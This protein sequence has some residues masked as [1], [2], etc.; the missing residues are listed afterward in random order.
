MT[1]PAGITGLRHRTDHIGG[2]VPCRTPE[3]AMDYDAGHFAFDVERKPDGAADG[4]AVP[5]GRALSSVLAQPAGRLAEMT[6]AGFARLGPFN[7]VQDLSAT[8]VPGQG[9]SYRLRPVNAAGETGPWTAWLAGVAVKTMGVAA[10]DALFDDPG[11][12]VAPY[13]PVSR[14]GTPFPSHRIGVLHLMAWNG[15]TGAAQ[16]RNLGLSTDGSGG[17]DMAAWFANFVDPLGELGLRALHIFRGP[18]GANLY[19]KDPGGSAF[20]IWNMPGGVNAD[21]N[22]QITGLLTPAEMIRR[23]GHDSTAFD[24]VPGVGSGVFGA[25]GYL[26][27]W[28]DE[29]PARI[30][31]GHSVQVYM[32]GPPR[33]VSDDWAATVR[34][35]LVAG[36]PLATGCT[37]SMDTFSSLRRDETVVLAGLESVNPA[38][39]LLEYLRSIG[40][41]P[42]WEPPTRREKNPDIGGVNKGPDFL[43]ATTDD[44][45]S[46]A[47]RWQLFQRLAGG[48]APTDFP[49]LDELLTADADRTGYAC[50][51]LQPGAIVPANI[52]TPGDN[53]KTTLA[54]AAAVHAYTL[55]MLASGEERFF[56]VVHSHAT[57]AAMWAGLD[58]AQRAALIIAAEVTGGTMA[59]ATL[60][61][62]RI[63]KH[64]ELFVAR[65]SYPANI[66][67]NAQ[68]TLSVTAG[69]N[70]Y[71]IT[72]SA[73]GLGGISIG[74]QIE[75]SGFTNADNNGFRKVTSASA[76]AVV[77]K[78]RGVGLDTNGVTESAGASVTISKVPGDVSTPTK[79]A[80]SLSNGTDTY[81]ATVKRGGFRQDSH[82]VYAYMD[83]EIDTPILH[84]DTITATVAAGGA[85]INGDGDQNAA[86]SAVAVENGSL[87]LDAGADFDYD[88]I[89]VTANGIPEAPVGTPAAVDPSTIS[90]LID[91]WAP[92]L[93]TGY[94]DGDDIGTLVGRVTPSNTLLPTSGASYPHKYEASVVNG[95]A[96]CRLKDYTTN[97]WRQAWTGASVGNF[98]SS[99]DRTV[100]AVF[101]YNGNTV[102]GNYRRIGTSLDGPPGRVNAHAVDL[103]TG[104][105][106]A[107]WASDS[108]GNGYGGTN[109]TTSSST[110]IRAA[111]I[112]IHSTAGPFYDGFV[113]RIYVFNR[114]LTA[115]EHASAV[116]W[117]LSFY[118]AKWQPEFHVSSTGSDSNPGTLASPLLTA[119]AGANRMNDRMGAHWVV[120]EDDNPN[121]SLAFNSAL[122]YT[123]IGVGYSITDPSV[124]RV[125]RTSGKKHPVF[126]QDNKQNIFTMTGSGNID[127]GAEHLVYYGA[128][129]REG[130]KI[131]AA[132]PVRLGRDAAYDDSYNSPGVMIS[133][134]GASTSTIR[135]DTAFI[136]CHGVGTGLVNVQ[137]E[138]LPQTHAWNIELLRTS[139]VHCFDDTQRAQPYFC[140]H[141]GAMIIDDMAGATGGWEPL[142]TAAD[143]KTADQNIFDHNFY[144]QYRVGNR[145][146][147]NV[148][149][150]RTSSHFIQARAG[151]YLSKSISVDDP[152][153]IF[154]ASVG[155]FTCEDMLIENGDSIAGSPRGWGL[156][157]GG[158]PDSTLRRIL[159]TNTGYASGFGVQING[160]GDFYVNDATA[161]PADAGGYLPYDGTKY[162]VTLE[163]IT[164]AGRPGT[165]F[166]FLKNANIAA[167]HLLVQAG[168]T[169]FVFT[170]TPTELTN[171]TTS[172]TN[173]VVDLSAGSFASVDSVVKTKA[174]LE[175]YLDVASGNTETAVTFHDNTRSVKKWAQTELGN[176][177]ATPLDWVY[178]VIADRATG[179]Y[180]INNEVATV[181]EWVEAGYYPTS[182]D[183]GDYGGV[184]PGAVQTVPAPE[185]EPGGAWRQPPVRSRA[186]TRSRVRA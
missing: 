3:L 110:G 169:A 62:F 78:I 65:W 139:Y 68:T 30:A 105:S 61:K 5:L 129:V 150:C 137:G 143:G 98:V 81:T 37:V 82:V 106:I 168:S 6:A 136:N 87:R 141:A 183:A 47:S 46:G 171:A 158:N 17:Y 66:Q 88:N 128:C 4:A 72:D 76:G 84:G 170:H 131:P 167:S 100:L 29:V 133:V 8:L 9:Y 80:V 12:A 162:R 180:D 93:E 52:A 85:W 73:N 23:H 40:Y 55:A 7:A 144:D 35:P 34:S 177:S 53:L 28:M 145:I 108:S 148:M 149:A 24:A 31:A 33:G 104:V 140:S 90:G 92:D 114:V 32:A 21:G 174:E 123:R 14:S 165:P 27:T 86:L 172:L 156:D 153:S 22:P 112:R 118:D 151:G 38:W 69:T 179:V 125:R 57:A 163:N 43:H 126:F 117:L 60:G 113:G 58:T 44:D 89:S 175:A 2:G 50:P 142:D 185:P 49:G 95:K 94:S 124:I 64:G 18:W 67:I 152:I 36:I 164:I 10:I 51:W 161:G 160:D 119:Q 147:R 54:D 111:Q 184:M 101:R 178:T 135:I 115:T 70:E 13:R 45:G 102:N 71:T 56:P 79:G 146:W 138:H 15:G 20:G 41:Q 122:D 155:G 159:L 59:D 121:I 83:G 77:V 26:A 39:L 132:S 91:W 134:V 103:N 186:A 1:P 11:A 75:I 157:V 116:R 74:D 42:G 25:S 96:M 166:K 120:A 19:A 154:A 109:Y 48:P 107:C 182:L 176:G 63:S 173:S 16:V 97:S 181:R 99:G 127:G 130:R